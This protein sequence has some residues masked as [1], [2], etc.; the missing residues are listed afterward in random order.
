[1]NKIKIIGKVVNEPQYSHSF[2]G[3]QFYEFSL[4]TTRKSGTVDSLVAV[5]P[6]LFLNKVI[7]G[8]LI[9]I[10]GEVRTRN[11]EDADGKRH[12]SIT[13]FIED[14]ETVE[15]SIDVNVVNISG[16]ICK[17]PFYRETPLGRQVCDFILASNRGRSNRTDYLPCIVWSRNAKR[18]AEMEVGTELEAVGRLQSRQY[19]RKLKDG[20]FETKTAYEISVSEIRVKDSE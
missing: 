3:E 7:V 20:T 17:P 11:Y 9:D 16:F 10:D 1:M 2:C 4:E 12:M 5:V 6:E 19:N 13:V 14:I 18:I 15:N 8:N